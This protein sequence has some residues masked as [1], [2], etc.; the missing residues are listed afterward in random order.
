[1]LLPY[2]VLDLT[3]GSALICGQILTDLGADVILAEPRAGLACGGWAPS[4]RTRPIRTPVCR[5]GP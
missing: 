3:D 1:M 5:S 4:T 2:R